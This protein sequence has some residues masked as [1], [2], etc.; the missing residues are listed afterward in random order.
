MPQEA[1][2]MGKKTVWNILWVCQIIIYFLR[3]W[4]KRELEFWLVK[5]GFLDLRSLCCFACFLLL[6][7]LLGFGGG[8]VVTKATGVS[9]LKEGATDGG[10]SHQD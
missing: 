7:G 8:G 5:K 3:K 4:R 9:L 6:F 1:G 10:F 2:A